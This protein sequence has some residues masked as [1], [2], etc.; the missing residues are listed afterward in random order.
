MAGSAPPPP[1]SLIP[2]PSP[3]SWTSYPV[4]ALPPNLPDIFKANA[5]PPSGTPQDPLG[6]HPFVWRQL[7]LFVHQLIRSPSRFRASGLP[8]L[9]REHPGRSRR[10]LRCLFRCCSLLGRRNWCEHA[11]PTP[12]IPNPI[13][14]YYETRI[15][16]SGR[17]HSTP[18]TR[19]RATLRYLA[20]RRRRRCRLLATPPLL[21]RSRHPLSATAPFLFPPFLGG[22]LLVFGHEKSYSRL[23]ATS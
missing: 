10:R 7:N 8:A 1:N 3:P 4:T 5:L 13:P 6:P 17:E 16:V 21:Y 19:P 18:W 20:R 9:F 23:P 12:S 11:G 2:T 14:L 15:W 22:C